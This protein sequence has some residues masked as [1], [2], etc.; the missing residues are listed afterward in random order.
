VQLIRNATPLFDLM[1]YKGA[2]D[3]RRFYEEVTLPRNLVVLGDA[4]CTFN[5]AYG[6][7]MTTAALQAIALQQQLQV[8]PI[9]VLDGVQAAN[10]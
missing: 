10:V 5:P 8:R 2:T 9:R 7:G 3:K 1:S 4:V 6:Q